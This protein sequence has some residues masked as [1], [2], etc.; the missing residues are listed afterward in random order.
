MAVH[1][2]L[3]SQSNQGQFHV[4][5]LLLAQWLPRQIIKEKCSFPC[6]FSLCGLF[7]FHCMLGWDDSEKRQNGKGPQI[8]ACPFSFLRSI[9]L[10]F[11]FSWSYPVLTTVSHVIY[12]L[13]DEAESS[14]LPKQESTNPWSSR[15]GA[16]LPFW[17]PLPV[18]FHHITSTQTLQLPFLF[19]KT[20][21]APLACHSVFYLNGVTTF[22]PS[23]TVWLKCHHFINLLQP[24][25]VVN[26][27][28]FE[29][30]TFSMSLHYKCFYN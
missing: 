6:V 4:T 3:P 24:S 23:F 28:L 20:F 14:L 5:L 1:I 13:Y 12:L 17:Y 9:K 8:E 30:L 21:E 11:S 25:Q 29:S 22:F 2:S 27:S 16:T 26:C 15:C 10:N 7:F 18:V 19:G